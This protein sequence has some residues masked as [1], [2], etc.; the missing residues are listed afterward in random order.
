[1]E[2][3]LPDD[4]ELV[5]LCDAVLRHMAAHRQSK[6]WHREAGGQL[7]G[8]FA[9]GAMLVEHITGPRRSDKR[10]R[11]SYRPDR[12]AE[13]REIH[14]MHAHGHHY[15]GDWHTHPEP[16]PAPSALDKATME[17]MFANSLT[18]AEGFLLVIAGTAAPPRG[19]HVSWITRAG[20]AKLSMRSAELAQA[21]QEITEDFGAERPQGH[22]IFG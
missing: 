18:Q 20:M 5:V 7:F 17:D 11:T 22:P 21:T 16:A 3:L 1:M 9:P 4:G 14:D 13:Q 15:M 19:L 2:Y 10:S 8:R 6:L 12:V